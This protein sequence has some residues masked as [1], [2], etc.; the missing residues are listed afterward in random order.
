MQVDRF[1]KQHLYKIYCLQIQMVERR[2]GREGTVQVNCI[3][4]SG[5]IFT[6]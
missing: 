6:V 5:G 1:H 2:G 4:V 3:L